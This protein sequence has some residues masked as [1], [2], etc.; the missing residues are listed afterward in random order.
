MAALVRLEE[1][2]LAFWTELWSRYAEIDRR[3]RQ[4]LSSQQARLQRPTAFDVCALLGTIIREK[5]HELS[6][7][8]LKQ[9]TA[10]EDLAQAEKDSYVKLLHD[11]VSLEFLYYGKDRDL[12]LVDNQ[13]VQLDFFT[14][15]AAMY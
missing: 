14:R 3:Y 7:D 12:A 4:Y 10:A 1:N 13:D 8:T 15:E 6:P 5:T 2:T 9:L 11:Q